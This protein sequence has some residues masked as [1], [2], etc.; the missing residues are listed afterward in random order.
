MVIHYYYPGVLGPEVL[1]TSGPSV[2]MD[3]V[4]LVPVY[5]WTRYFWSQ[6]THGPGPSGPSVPMV[7][8]LMVPVSEISTILVN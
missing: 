5:P 4:I 2:P 7:Q 8:V 3:Q 6:Y 1:G